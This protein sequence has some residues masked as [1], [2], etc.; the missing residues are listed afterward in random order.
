MSRSRIIIAAIGCLI[1]L[2]YLFSTSS[3]AISQAHSLISPS[4]QANASITKESIRAWLGEP[5]KVK[6]GAKGTETWIY[7]IRPGEED[8]PIYRVLTNYRSVRGFIFTFD[9][10]GILK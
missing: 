1:A 7:I 10:D 5:T 8:F 4:N 6:H 2:T 9:K 3:P